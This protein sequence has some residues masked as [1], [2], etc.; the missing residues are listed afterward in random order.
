MDK[1]TNL[2]IQNSSCRKE[3]KNNKYSNKLKGCTKLWDDY[4]ERKQND[5]PSF[6]S[7]ILP[8]PHLLVPHINAQ[9]NRHSITT[10]DFVWNITLSNITKILEAGVQDG[11][12]QEA[13]VKWMKQS[14]DSG[15]LYTLRNRFT[16]TS[17]PKFSARHK[18]K[19]NLLCCSFSACLRETSADVNPKVS[20]WDDVFKE[21]PSNS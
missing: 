9:G 5:I 13:F 21:W 18:T 2:Q 12:C 4:D 15:P 11:L 10:N 17:W 16:G 1:W 3:I 8:L 14:R 6:L 19:T 7:V 20:N